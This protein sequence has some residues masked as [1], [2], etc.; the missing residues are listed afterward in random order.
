MKKKINIFNFEEQP[1][2][3]TH[4][5]KITNLYLGPWCLKKRDLYYHKNTNYIDLQLN[6]NK[7]QYITDTKN[8][9][10]I[11]E[12]FL[13]K[14]T[15][16]LNKIH[17]INFSKTEWQIILGR[18][19]MTWINHLHFHWVYVDKIFMKYKINKIYTYKNKNKNFIPT[20]TWSSHL[21]L[22]NEIKWSEH[23][24][25]EILNFKKKNKYNKII[26][27][28]KSK[29]DRLNKNN[30]RIPIGLFYKSKERFIL[31]NLGMHAKDKLKLKLKYFNF[32]I[33]VFKNF[34]LKNQNINRNNLSF[35]KNKSEFITFLSEQIKFAIPKSF[36]E[37]FRSIQQLVIASKLPKKV[38]FVF[39]SYAQYYDEFFKIYVANLIY[40]NPK[41]KLC[42]LQHGYGG[43]FKA[44]DFYNIYLDKKIS[45]IFLAWG[46][47]K[48]DKHT[49]FCY[50][51]DTSNTVSKFS[52]KKGI[53]ILSYSFNYL[54]ITPIDGTING[55]NI[56]RILFKKLKNFYDNLF[57]NIKK[58]I[59][60]KVQV[61][62]EKNNLG[63]TLKKNLDIKLIKNEEKFL[64][65]FKNYNLIIH[66]FVG[67]G[68]FEC[69]AKNIPSILIYSEKC[70]FPFDNHFKDY[71][72][73]MKS[74]SMM[75]ENEEKASI[76][77]NKNYHKIINWW[78]SKD[79]QELVNRMCNEYCQRKDALKLIE[80]IIKK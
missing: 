8:L 57:K 16:N 21:Y 33:N 40:K 64:R 56:D 76:F 50:P 77:L 75:F 20:N 10:K 80:R 45:N 15:I 35:P 59:H 5:N 29:S 69:L 63:H 4:N 19:L 78:A 72:K 1:I 46:N 17:S 47:L 18:W 73:K 27:L 70:H 79:V 26:G 22:R 61:I 51:L 3:F 23:I 7:K 71:L 13:D 9:E 60:V 67:T 74:M 31:Y 24:F 11:Y 2:K 25:L 53:L 28:S 36:L 65:I 52:N 32:G 54:L 39:T 44:D 49:P 14:I 68:F 41:T 34:K 6:T 30:L 42:I 58:K 37:N 38:D 55:I 48:K 66:T 43:I 62:N 12:F